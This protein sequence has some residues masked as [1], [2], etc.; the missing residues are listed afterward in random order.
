MRQNKGGDSMASIKKMV[1]KNGVSYKITVSSGRGPDGKQIRHFKTYTPPPDLTQRQAEKEALRTAVE[2]ERAI[3]TGFTVDSRSTFEQYIPHFL[4]VKKL[5]GVEIT[6]LNLYE[7]SLKQYACPYIGHMKM[8]SIKPQH[9]TNIYK[10]LSEPGHNT[11]NKYMTPKQCFSQMAEA[12]GLSHTEFM[13]KYGLPLWVSIK[14]RQGKPFKEETAKWIA[15]A[16]GK[17]KEQLF[18]AHEDKSGLSAGTIKRLHTCIS[19]LFC[20]AEREMLIQ[21][22]PSKLAMVPIKKEQTAIRYFQPDE[23]G[24]IA[25]ALEDEPIKWKVLMH[26]LIITGCRRGEALGLRWEKVDFENGIVTIDRSLK[27][28]TKTK[29]RYEGRTKT[30]NA[31]TLHLPDQLL[32]ELKKLRAWQAEERLKAGDQWEVSPYVFTDDFGGSMPLDKP[33]YWLRQFSNR[34]GLQ[35][36]NLHAFRHSAASEMV[37]NGTDIAT[38]SHILGHSNPTTTLNVYSHVIKTREIDAIESIAKALED[39]GAEYSQKKKA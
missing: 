31:R 28:D 11:R 30:G 19:S 25:A 33:G 37:A 6:T 39:R 36:I 17:P 32:R 1:G 38:V 13:N 4:D 14:I 27:A 29:T 9:I 16:I 22:N 5:S 12:S 18:D 26:F 7:R 8:T 24:A 35:H 15:K 10:I 3:E 21:Y 23:M 20:L 34:H 2:F